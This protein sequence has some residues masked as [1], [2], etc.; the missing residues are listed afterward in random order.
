MVCLLKIKI[1]HQYHQYIIYAIFSS[2]FLKP[3]FSRICFSYYRKDLQDKNKGY[4][5]MRSPWEEPSSILKYFAVL[6]LFVIYYLW[7]CDRFSPKLLFLK[8]RLTFRK[9]KP[10]GFGLLLLIACRLKVRL[11]LGFKNVFKNI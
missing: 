9:L 3:R 10:S 11:L 2:N 5:M 6:Q 4:L 1:C 7:F 8:E